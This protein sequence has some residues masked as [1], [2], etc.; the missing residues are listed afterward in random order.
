M[1]IPTPHES[2]SGDFKPLE[3]STDKVDLK[4]FDAPTNWIQS[5]TNPLV[6][7]NKITGK[8]RTKDFTYISR[9]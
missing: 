2:D 5:P 8:M 6:E 1:S 7:I 4:D 3:K 9:T